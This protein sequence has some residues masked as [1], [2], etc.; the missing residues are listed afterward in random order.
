MVNPNQIPHLIKLLDDESLEVQEKILKELTSF[1][2]ILTEELR[3][4]SFVPNPVQFQQLKRIL[5]EQKRTRLKQVWLSWF[6]LK[7]DPDKLEKALGY[8]S[9]WLSDFESETR[10][11]FLLDQLAD[12]YQG[13]FHFADERL[14]A[15]FLFRDKSFS[16]NQ[17]DYYNP[18]NSNLIYVVDQKKGIPLSLSCLYILL[19]NRL[20]LNIMG[21]PYPGHFLAKINVNGKRVFVDCF[22]GGQLLDEG[23]IVRTFQDDVENINRILNENADTETIVKRFLANLIHSYQLIADEKRVVFI[24]DLIKN[25]DLK[26]IERKCANL[27]P[28]DIISQISANFKVGAK[29]KHKRFG[30]R[31]IIVDVDSYCKAPDHW[32]YSTQIQSSPNEPWYHILIHESDQVSYVSQSNLI[33]DDSNKEVNHPLL[34]YFFTKTEVGKYVR[35]ANPWPGP[36]F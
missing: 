3:K 2:P 22:N 27:K 10:L 28:E 25:L 15:Q 1:G 4:L 13:K 14:L 35:N 29:I 36:E 19:G 5:E 8:I 6:E 26:I 12:E 20:G 9:H 11:T 23:D 34:T 24:L 32:Y 17:K 7:E 33:R 30:Y 16:G 21:C 31:G 18:Q